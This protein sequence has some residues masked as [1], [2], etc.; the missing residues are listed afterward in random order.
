MFTHK[1]TGYAD[2]SH[3]TVTEARECEAETQADE[4]AAMADFLA[5]RA[6]ENAFDRALERR[7]EPGHGYW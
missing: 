4:D 3:A 6:A 5:E 7:S 1:Q 2:H